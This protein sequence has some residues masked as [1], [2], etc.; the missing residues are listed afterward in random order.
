[1]ESELLTIVMFLMLGGLIFLG[2]PIVFALGT[3]AVIIGYLLWGSNSL[4]LLSSHVHGVI[5]NYTLMALPFFLFMSNVLRESNIAEDIYDFMH[6]WTGALPGG[7]AI[8][9]VLT[10]AIIAALSGVS[11]VGVMAMGTLAM[12]AMIAR[13]Y[14]KR[15][16]AGAILGGGAL[17]QL[18]PPSVLALVYSN[19]ATV[20]VGK[21]FL[22]GVVPGIL[23]TG[24]FVFYILI[25]SLINKNL[26]PPM[27]PEELAEITWT[28][29]F[30]S[31]LKIIPP[32]LIIL[33]VL[34]SLFAGIASPTESAAVGA[35]ASL[36]LAICYG[37]INLVKLQSITLETLKSSAMVL[38]IATSSLLFVAVYTGLGGSNFIRETLMNLDVGPHMILLVIMLFVFLLGAVMDPVG[39]IYLLAPIVLPIIIALDFDPIWFG[40]IFIVCLETSYLTPPFGYN[41]FYLKAVASDIL[42]T[43]DVYAATPPYIMLQ[44]LALILCIIFPSIITWLPNYVFGY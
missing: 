42:S 1:M 12:P 40:G 15:I 8:G 18:I 13:G 11:A 36:L 34:G 27:A 35:A 26:C 7:L 4:F 21:M 30:S 10:C 16:S 44:V 9:T 32:V 37:R 17:G 39:I 20:S 6:K 25:R 43:K 19:I 22:A 14:N 23:L 38:W 33:A 29:R 3:V 2:V 28:I 24:L 5:F 31:L 41:L